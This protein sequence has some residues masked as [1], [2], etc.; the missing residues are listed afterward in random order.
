M[1]VKSRQKSETIFP[2]QDLEDDR[3]VSL[4]A[5]LKYLG[6]GSFSQRGKGKPKGF[7]KAVGGI[8]EE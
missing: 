5:N 4:I 1:V 6:W 2:T 3:M 7:G 8:K